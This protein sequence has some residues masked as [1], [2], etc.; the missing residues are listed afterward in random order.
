MSFPGKSCKENAIKEHGWQR[1]WGMFMKVNPTCGHESIWK[2]WAFT[3][4]W[5]DSVSPFTQLGSMNRLSSP[6]I[7]CSLLPSLPPSFLSLLLSASLFL[8]YP[9]LH[10]AETRGRKRT[11]SLLPLL[12]QGKSHNIQLNTIP[13]HRKPP[14]TKDHFTFLTRRRPLPVRACTLTV[15]LWKKKIS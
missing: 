8:F 11:H 1:S 13:P 5:A 12:H 15:L 3:A 7:L 4:L 6:S 14:N 9:L 2:T 10:W